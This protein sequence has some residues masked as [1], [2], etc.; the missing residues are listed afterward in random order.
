MEQRPATAAVAAIGALIVLGY[1]ASSLG[2]QIDTT[3]RFRAMYPGEWLVPR[4]WE[5]GL[6]LNAGLSTPVR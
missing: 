4:F 2:E 5:Q 1:A 3:A 6:L